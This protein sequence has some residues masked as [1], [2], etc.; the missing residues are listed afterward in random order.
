MNCTVLNQT[1]IAGFLRTKVST[2]DAL[3]PPKSIAVMANAAMAFQC[4]G[5]ATCENVQ[6][7]N[8]NNSAA[9]A[10]RV[11]SSAY[12]P[13][14]FCSRPVAFGMRYQHLWKE[15]RDPKARYQYTA[16]SAKNNFATAVNR[17][18]SSCNIERHPLN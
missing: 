1:L 13:N 17:K 4:R 16:P 12:S 2:I 10:V 5:P 6:E 8:N 7:G 9:T 11:P 14:T 3:R 15:E 18:A